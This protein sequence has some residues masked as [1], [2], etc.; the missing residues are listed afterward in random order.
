MSTLHVT[1]EELNDKIQNLLDPNKKP[2]VVFSIMEIQDMDNH[3]WNYTV[4][5]PDVSS[6]EPVFEGECQFRIDYWRVALK[7]VTS[8]VYTNPTWKD[9]INACNDLLQDGDECGVY[10]ESINWKETVDGIKIY[11]FGIGS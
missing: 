2:L 7:P 3:N 8:P 5:C 9:I 1:T 6:P 4:V 10:L 11:E